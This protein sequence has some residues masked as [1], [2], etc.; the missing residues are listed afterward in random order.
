MFVFRDRRGDLLKIIWW[1][2]QGACLFTKRLERGRHRGPRGNG[3]RGY[4]DRR[5]YWLDRWCVLRW[6]SGVQADVTPGRETGR[7][8]GL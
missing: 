1:D 6:A 2:S 3:P 5:R 8:G 4:A 7:R